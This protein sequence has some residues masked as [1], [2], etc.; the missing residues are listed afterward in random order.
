[1]QK[2]MH[3]LS[4][5]IVAALILALSGPA[6]GI[7]TKSRMSQ[8]NNVQLSFELGNG[9]F[10]GSGMF[11]KGS[12]NLIPSFEGG[13]GNAMAIARDID[14]DGAMEDTSNGGSRGRSIFGGNYSLESYD[15]LRALYDG[16]EARMDQACNRLENNRVWSS[17]DPDD[18]ADWPPEFREGRSVS[19]AP[20]LHGAETILSRFGNAFNSSFAGGVPAPG[21]SLEYRCHFMNFGESNDMIYTHLFIRNMSEYIKWGPNEVIV[22][23]VANTPDGQTWNF[24]LNFYSTYLGIGAS[25]AGMDD[26][27]IMHSEKAIVALADPDGMEGGFTRGGNTFYIAHKMIRNPVVNGEEMV[28]TGHHG[29]RWGNDFGGPNTKDFFSMSDAGLCYRACLGELHPNP[30][31]V[32]QDMYDGQ[33]NPL[34]GRPCWGWPGRLLPADELYDKWVWGKE[35]R[36]QCTIYAE[37][38]DFAP[39]DSTSCDFVTMFVYPA[40]PPAVFLVEDIANIYDP[41]LQEQAV[42]IEQYAAVAQ[43]VFEGDFILPETP[44]PPPLT[45][46]PGDRAVTI[47]WSNVN[48]NTSDAYYAFIQEHPDLDPGGIYR[49]YDFEGYRLYRSF[50]GPSDSHSEMIFE[51]SLGANNVVFYYNDKHTLDPPYNRLR[52]GMRTWY[53]LV[54]YDRNYDPATGEMLSL[55]DPA[56]GK[57][58]NRPREGLYTVTPRSEATNFKAATFGGGTYVGPASVPDAIAELT[59]HPVWRYDVLDEPTEEGNTIDTVLVDKLLDEAP[60]WLQPQLDFT[61]E[62]VNNERITQDLTLY[63]SG[64]RRLLAVSSMCRMLDPVTEMKLLDGNRNDMGPAGTG[65]LNGAS[66]A[67]LTVMNTADIDGVNYAL[68]MIYEST[69]TDAKRDFYNHFDP[70]TYTGA[71]ITPATTK[72][73]FG[74]RPTIGGMIRAGQFEVTWKE[75]GGGLSV[76]VANNTRGITV[77][78]GPYADE[79]V[80]GFMPGGT[81]M[82][83]YNDL[84][85]GV[86]QADRTAL[87]LETMPAD[88]TDEFAL[89]VN[90]IVW[91]FTDITEMPAAGTK[92]TIDNCYGSFNEE[93]T[94]FTQ[95]ADPPDVGDEWQLTINAMTLDPEDADLTK[96]RVV[97][98][99]Y[100]ASST[101]DLSPLSRRIEFVNLPDRCTIRIYTLGGNLVNVLNHIGSNRFGWGNFTDVDRITPDNTPEVFTGYDNHGGTE[102]WNL[103]NRFGQTVASG[104]YFFH[105]TDSRGETHTGR[106]YIVN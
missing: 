6:Y 99:P 75:A 76:D 9:L 3:F 62:V 60:K 32:A 57:T 69:G 96:I 21:P 25:A 7:M 28:F 56:S 8:G 47:T 29:H 2:N 16:G 63:V 89:Y 94:V 44:V 86:P 64:T 1:M 30:D 23:Q 17:L 34:T 49:E 55:P 26:C 53:A 37:A 27:W 67:E 35:G 73:V 19:G 11:P 105:V 102:P 106:F 104:L 24:C 18:M 68:T 77:P 61:L 38:R 82:D 78:F 59:G 87:L 14:G 72:C 51:C 84:D 58:W 46:I 20:I 97:P 85:G 74:P 92:F 80:W 31:E 52:N 90:G 83:F 70:G 5:L 66:S 81:Y 103:R 50:V 88:N 15:L 36:Q 12:G 48:V 10:T 93:M 13:W 42:T 100:L 95:N 41:D 79:Q 40:N 43:T 65:L 39:R 71:T 45:I 54:P 22:E 98:N 91:E 101:L 4:K 33:L